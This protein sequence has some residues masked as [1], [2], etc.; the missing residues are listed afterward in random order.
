MKLVLDLLLGAQVV[1]VAALGLA[2]VGGARVQ[3]SVALATDHL[4]A[5]V[6]HGQDP[7]RWLNST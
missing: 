4:I 6:L 2:A 1:G 7:K 5:V 3:A